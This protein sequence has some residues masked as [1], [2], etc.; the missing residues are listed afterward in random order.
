MTSGVHYTFMVSRF[1]LGFTIAQST[2]ARS[3]FNP[4]F[5]GRGRSEL[6]K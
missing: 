2:V 4:Y 1:K 6:G 3:D 5:E